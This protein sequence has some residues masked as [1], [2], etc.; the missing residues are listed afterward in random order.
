MLLCAGDRVFANPS[1]IVGS[2]GV[3][4]GGFGFVD[5]IAKLGI[6]RRLLTSGAFKSQLDPFLPVDEG[7]RQ[8]HGELLRA[9]H[10][11]FKALVLEARG[12]KLKDAVK[13]QLMEAQVFTGREAAESGVVDAVGELREVLRDAFGKDVVIKPISTQHRSLWDWV[14]TQQLAVG[15][16]G[17]GGG[18]AGRE[19]VEALADELELRAQMEAAVGPVGGAGAL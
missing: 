16:G 14:P 13:P 5:A 10:E 9:L 19:V 8:R 2:V 17:A 15:L 18:G 7:H 3:I 11:E 1:S 4:G 6:E 12:T